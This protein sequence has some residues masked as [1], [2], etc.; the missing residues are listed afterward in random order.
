MDT[1]NDVVGTS[2]QLGPILLARMSVSSTLGLPW[3]LRYAGGQG[4]ANGIAR[5][6]AI[7]V[8]LGLEK[9]AA[10]IV[11]NLTDQGKADIVAQVTIEMLNNQ[12]IAEMTAINQ[13]IMA[14]GRMDVGASISSEMLK[15]GNTQFMEVLNNAKEQWKEGKG[16]QITAA[17]SASHSADKKSVVEQVRE[18][19]ASVTQNA[20][21]SDEKAAQAKQ[22]EAQAHKSV[23]QRI[24]EALYG[25]DSTQDK[26]A[27]QGQGVGQR[28]SEVVHGEDSSQGKAASEAKDAGRT[29]R[30]KLQSGAATVLQEAKDSAA[31]AQ[32]A[33]SQKA[34][35]ASQ[36]AGSALDRLDLTAKKQEPSR[37]L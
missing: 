20:Q 35:E 5:L 32:E 33:V 23:G 8:N 14:E 18:G 17:P 1:I 3:G 13:A 26:A 10:G 7:I 2:W 24:S 4:N 27:S 30:E 29:T 34:S 12:S 15:R 28:I 11:I 22:A 36:A 37:T 9:L 19:V 21:G 31:V 16:A 6:T 25:E